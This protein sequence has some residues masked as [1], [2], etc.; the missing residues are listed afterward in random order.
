MLKADGFDSAIIGTVERADM[1]RVLLYDTHKCIEI[2]MSEHGLT[3]E[4]ATEHFYFNVAGAYVGRETPCYALMQ[5]REELLE[6][7]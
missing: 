1:G 6:L 5:S 3:E 2:L 4:L 7:D